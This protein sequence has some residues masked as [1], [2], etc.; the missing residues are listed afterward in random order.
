MKRARGMTVTA[1]TAAA[2]VLV[3]TFGGAAQAANNSEQVIFSGTGFGTFANQPSPFGFWIWCEADSVNPY[4]GNCAGSIYIYGLGL[5]KGVSGDD[6]IT[7]PSE[8]M[9]VITVGSRDGAIACTLTNTPP[10]TRG[11]TN[12]VSVTCTSP[13]GGGTVTNAVVRATGPG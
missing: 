11:P 4:Q 13:S 7:E 10:I 1:M 8:H 5:V 2:V 6:A 12:T 9:Y 3:A